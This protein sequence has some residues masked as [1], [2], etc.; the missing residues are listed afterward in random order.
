MENLK[1]L[2][3]MAQTLDQVVFMTAT[4]LFGYVMI[5]LLKRQNKKS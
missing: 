1:D 3:A 5:G 2:L 4:L